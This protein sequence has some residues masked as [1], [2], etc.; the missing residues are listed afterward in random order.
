MSK[1]VN[2][3]SFFG[4]GDAILERK[5]EVQHEKNVQVVK[6]VA[7]QEPNKNKRE[8]AVERTIAIL[9][10]EKAYYNNVEKDARRILNSCINDAYRR[11]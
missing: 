8:Q 3:M 6:K 5:I 1:K 7:Q 2:A 11:G 9:E 4:I 10:S